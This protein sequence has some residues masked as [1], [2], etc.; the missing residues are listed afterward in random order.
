MALAIDQFTT[1][2][3]HWLLYQKTILPIITY[4]TI[5]WELIGAIIVLSPWKTA[6]LRMIAILGF[7]LMHLG[8]G[9]CLELGLFPYGFENHNHISERKK[10]RS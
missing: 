1:P 9:F 2:F 3:G 6:R 7:S 8:L 4:S 10:E 5:V